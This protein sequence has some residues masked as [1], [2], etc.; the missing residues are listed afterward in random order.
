MGMLVDN[1]FGRGESSLWASAIRHCATSFQEDNVPHDDTWADQARGKSRHDETQA[2]VEVFRGLHAPLSPEEIRNYDSRSLENLLVDPDLVKHAQ[3]TSI[4]DTFQG[5]SK[6]IGDSFV[7][8]SSP[9]N[10]SPGRNVALIFDDASALS[11][12]ARKLQNG[13]TDS[14]RAIEVIKKGFEIA[15][16][17]S[18]NEWQQEIANIKKWQQELEDGHFSNTFSRE[19]G[20]QLP[21]NPI[22]SDNRAK[23]FEHTNGDIPADWK[24]SSTNFRDTADSDVEVVSAARDGEVVETE[25][26]R[27]VAQLYASV[28]NAKSDMTR[29]TQSLTDFVARLPKRE[30]NSATRVQ[31]VANF[32]EQ[33]P[34]Q[35]EK[36]IESSAVQDATL[37]ISDTQLPGINEFTANPKP[38]QQI[39][40][41]LMRKGAVAETTNYSQMPRSLE[42]GLLRL[43]DG[44]REI[45]AKYG[46]GHPWSQVNAFQDLYAKKLKERFAD[47]NETG[48]NHTSGS[49]TALISTAENPDTEGSV[50]TEGSASAVENPATIEDATSW[51]SSSGDGMPINDAG[52][53]GALMKPYDLRN[54]NNDSNE[55]EVLRQLNMADTASHEMQRILFG[56]QKAGGGSSNIGE[57][58]G[59]LPD[60][61]K[62]NAEFDREFKDQDLL[63]SAPDLFGTG[64]K[65]S[66]VRN[67]DVR[68][69]SEM[70][71]AENLF[72]TDVNKVPAPM[73]DE[74][75]PSDFDSLFSRMN[76][77]SVDPNTGK[78]DINR[79]FSSMDE[80]GLIN[81][82]NSAMALIAREDL[83]SQQQDLSALRRL[84]SKDV[85]KYMEDLLAK[86]GMKLQRDENGNLSG[87]KLGGDNQEDSIMTVKRGGSMSDK[88]VKEDSDEVIA[89][90]VV[91]ALREGGDDVH[92]ISPGESKSNDPNV[93][94]VSV[95]DGDSG[96][97]VEK[98]MVGEMEAN[99]GAALSPE[100]VVSQSEE[101]KQGT[102][103]HEDIDEVLA[104]ELEI[105]NLNA[106]L[107][108]R[109][110]SLFP[111]LQVMKTLPHMNREMQ[112]LAQQLEGL[113]QYVGD[114]GLLGSSMAVH[115]SEQSPEV[116]S[117]APDTFS[118]PDSKNM[119]R[120]DLT[121]FSELERTATT[122]FK[123]SS[124]SKFPPMFNE[125]RDLL[126]LRNFKVGRNDDPGEDLGRFDFLSLSRSAKVK[127]VEDASG[128]NVKRNGYTGYSA[129]DQRK[130]GESLD[131]ESSNGTAEQEDPELTKLEGFKKSSFMPVARIRNA[132]YRTNFMPVMHNAGHRSDMFNIKNDIMP[133]LGGKPNEKSS[134][135]RQPHVWR[136]TSSVV[137]D[138]SAGGLT[139]SFIAESHNDPQAGPGMG[140]QLCCAKKLG[141][142]RNDSKC[143]K[144][145]FKCPNG[146]MNLKKIELRGRNS[147]VRDKIRLDDQFHVL[148]VGTPQQPKLQHRN[149][150]CWEGC[151]EKEGYISD[152]TVSENFRAIELSTPGAK[153]RK[154][155]TS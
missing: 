19:A 1:L 98:N 115:S 124:F 151:R 41:P 127:E 136:A 109:D 117:P 26:E 57:L 73:E 125:E 64:G 63:E 46:V 18:M 94:I 93:I 80:M 96:A 95:C 131:P 106:G 11:K 83:M 144:G 84:S 138:G 105:E 40:L 33:P 104:K 54:N 111:P 145:F 65:V 39:S 133:L 71:K 122:S 146:C 137:C 121:Q 135:C 129:I 92:E 23:T 21:G 44:K 75:G 88:D 85:V 82:G 118:A 90:R 76:A 134:Q 132:R 32:I 30:G 155:E 116:G 38:D 29:S 42:D 52:D 101:E 9:A 120:K 3:Y 86:K 4:M 24:F 112:L 25:A 110:Y 47:L 22:M 31:R 107:N 58:A 150:D 34:V 99:G 6:D 79:Y 59:K 78:F 81:A 72:A 148:T 12:V 2:Q 7:P 130:L 154:F 51:N 8:E 140:M 108:E 114:S 153:L 113:K 14:S 16:G 10:L 149:E 50:S 123:P 61:N 142:C 70:Q 27:H 13:L 103:A 147:L 62:I 102:L 119:P 141:R 68:K 5:S 20:A 74:E 139:T 69:L 87:E 97:S 143:P 15:T 77:Q 91:Q 66:D 100:R 37:E 43:L 17:K 152:G 53:H 48:G 56:M 60:V 36:T 89:N 55:E 28:K 126:D 49:V 67:T 45:M 128:A 35:H